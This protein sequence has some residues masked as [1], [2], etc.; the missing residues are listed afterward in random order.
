LP[1]GDEKFLKSSFGG[2]K[3]SRREAL[4]TGAKIGLAAG[5]GLVAGAVAGYFGGTLTRPT[6]PTVKTV[7]ETVTAPTTITSTITKTV[8]VATPVT[9]TKKVAIEEWLKDVTR[10]FKGTT[11][12]I[13]AESTPPSG[14]I[15]SVLVPR[16][17]ELTGIKVEMERLGWDDVLKKELLD[18]EGKSGIYDLYYIDELEV[19]A[20][21]F[22]K[23]GIIDVYELMEAKPDL[24][25]PEFDLPDLIP[26]SYF[27]YEGKLAGI[28][29]EFFLRLYTYRKDLFNDPTEKRNFEKEYGWEL[30]PPKTWDEYEQIAKF[31]TRPPDLY[32]HITMPSPGTIAFDFWM[33][34]W[35]YGLPNGGF[36]LKRRTSV[37]EGGLLDS[38]RSIVL[39]KRYINLL[40]YGSPGIFNFTWDELR[41]EFM[42]GRVAQGIIFG[43][44]LPDVVGSPESKVRGKVDVSLP[45]VEP[46]YYFPGLPIIYGDMGCWAIS[47]ASKNKEAALLFLQW[48]ACKENAQREMSE[49]GGLCTRKSLLFSPLADEIDKKFNWS[50][51]KVVRQVIMSNLATGPF[52]AVPEILIYRDMLYP[53]LTKAVAGELTPE[54][55][56][57]NAANEIDK[58]MKELGF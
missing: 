8:S 9:E 3:V 58:K 14:W 34:G 53:W 20:T 39:L 48:V 42:T 49:L 4:S 26:V 24:V 13:I 21:F 1:E 28:P 38:D 57:R 31:F 35:T 6:T 40:K 27:T 56:L 17:E 23:G 29:F 55:A 37:N 33:L 7:T 50:Y 16:F 25:Y 19:M 11:I 52:V 43:D 32:G 5:L 2:K 18:I 12:R 51:L 36:T 22:D 10:P 46:K 54:E 47:S 30:A 41:S 15:N 44:Q 45:P